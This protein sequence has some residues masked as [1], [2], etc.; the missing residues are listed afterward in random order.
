MTQVYKQLKNM[1]NNSLT[2]KMK[3]RL[4]NEGYFWNIC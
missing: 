1:I 2:Q 4:I 3:T